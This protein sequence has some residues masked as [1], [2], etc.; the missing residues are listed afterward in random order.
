MLKLMNWTASAR[1]QVKTR[2]QH[3]FLSDDPLD[4]CY[5]YLPTS[6]RSKLRLKEKA[7][8]SLRWSPGLAQLCTQGRCSVRELA[9]V[10]RGVCVHA[11]TQACAHDGQ[12]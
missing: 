9:L 3:L 4:R 10:C 8:Q 5:S 6:Q 11:R 12:G 1:H 7:P 2:S